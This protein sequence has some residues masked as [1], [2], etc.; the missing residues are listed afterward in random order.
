MFR[1]VDINGD[2][3]ISLEDFGLIVFPNLRKF[4]D[5]LLK[6]QEASRQIAASNVSRFDEA[7]EDEDEDGDKDDVRSTAPVSGKDSVC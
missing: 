5:V 6:E 4:E 1:A 2:A 3:T 7:D